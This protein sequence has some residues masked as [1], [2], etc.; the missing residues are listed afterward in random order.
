MT[1]YHPLLVALHWIIATMI[2]LSLVVGGPALADMDNSDPEK[3]FGLTGHAWFGVGILIFM[4]IRILTRVFSTAPPETE[5]SNQLEKIAARW[6]HRLL[7]V[8]VLAMCFSG[9]SLAVTSGVGEI[10]FGGADK[11]LPEDF[12]VFTPRILHGIFAKVLLTLVILHVAAALFHQ[13]VKKDALISRM[14]FG[15]RQS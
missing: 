12:M 13:F 7:Y 2:F 11:P 4:V 6:M 15:K 10:I 8:F 5:S 3:L 14:W 1:R 9:I